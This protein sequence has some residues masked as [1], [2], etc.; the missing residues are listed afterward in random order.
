MARNGAWKFLAVAVRQGMRT[1]FGPKRRMF[2]V[3]LTHECIWDGIIA[4][5]GMKM[6]E[7]TDSWGNTKAVLASE[8]VTAEDRAKHPDSCDG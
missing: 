7:E 2:V 8:L 5:V 4:G 1:F 6:E 3:A